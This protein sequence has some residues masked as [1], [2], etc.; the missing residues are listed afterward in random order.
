MLHKILSNYPELNSVCS[1]SIQQVNSCPASCLPCSESKEPSGLSALLLIPS[2]WRSLARC[3]FP[4]ASWLSFSVWSFTFWVL[5]SS[6]PLQV[7]HIQLHG[8]KSDKENRSINMEPVDCYKNHVK[9]HNG[10]VVSPFSGP[11]SLKLSVIAD[12]ICEL[13]KLCYARCEDKFEF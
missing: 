1:T 9:I 5:A 2:P 7:E 4:L 12:G 13:Q 10:V 11:P 8:N 3:P 6:F